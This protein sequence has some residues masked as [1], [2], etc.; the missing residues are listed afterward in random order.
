MNAKLNLES[1][2]EM[3][4]LARTLEIAAA[5]KALEFECIE[6]MLAQDADRREIIMFDSEARNT[7][8]EGL[9]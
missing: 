3:T 1:V 5:A 8:K 9:R 7:M 6:R 4:S 2:I